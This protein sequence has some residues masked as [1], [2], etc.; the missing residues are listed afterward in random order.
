MASGR[1]IVTNGV[2]EVAR[3]FID[4]KN[5][6]VCA[7]GSPNLY[8]KKI[9]E[10]LDNPEEAFCVGFQGKQTAYEHFHYQ[11]HAQRFA[12]FVNSLALGD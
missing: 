2:G 1:P 3:Y 6:Y 4:K 5:A 7:P 8:G 10:L 9:I 11:I 12:N